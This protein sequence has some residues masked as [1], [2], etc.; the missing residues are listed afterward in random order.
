MFDVLLHTSHQLPITIWK[1][2]LV[3]G[4]MN[5]FNSYLR[6]QLVI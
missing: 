4:M 5:V 1:L 2:K 3:L 6:M